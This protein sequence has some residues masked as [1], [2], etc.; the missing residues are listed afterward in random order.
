MKDLGFENLGFI[1]LAVIYLCF[2]LGSSYSAKITDK[3]GEKKTLIF[4]ALAYSLWICC[5]LFPVYKYEQN[6]DDTGVAN[7]TFI[8][9]IN[10]SSAVIIGFSAA[11]LWTS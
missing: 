11:M 7:P 3:L 5:F 8:K 4:S 6:L 1:N 10:I 9:I 2:C